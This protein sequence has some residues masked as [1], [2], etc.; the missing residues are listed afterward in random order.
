MSNAIAIRPVS[1][2]AEFGRTPT[3][4]QHADTLLEF[5]SRPADSFRGLLDAA[6]LALVVDE[7]QAVLATPPAGEREARAE[8]MTMIGS[9]PRQPDNPE[10]YCGAMA[11]EASRWPADVIREARR[12]IVRTLKFLPSVAE[13]AG[14]CESIQ[15]RRRLLLIAA[16]RMERERQRRETE[17]RRRA[18][19]EAQRQ[20]QRIAHH[21]ALRN[22]FGELAIDAGDFDDAVAAY[23][24]APVS[25]P[26]IV[27]LADW[28]RAHDSA[29]AWAVALGRRAAVIGYALRLQRAGV[30]G[31]DFATAIAA[32]AAKGEAEEARRMLD[33][34]EAGDPPGIGHPTADA[35]ALRRQIGAALD[36]SACEAEAEAFQSQRAA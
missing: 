9:F 11:K 30:V 7:V 24:H 22:Q 31:L 35:V 32:M 14:A 34:A 2:V 15:G 13:L 1:A 18:T 20:A 28:L 23:R 8:I 12:T 33:R 4:E 10:I 19:A 36:R 17:E 16:E 27:S 25:H 3:A 6:T 21:T 26:G 29:Q 5:V